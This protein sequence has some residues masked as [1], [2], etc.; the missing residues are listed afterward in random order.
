MSISVLVTYASKYG[1]TQ[2]VAESVA[3][4]LRDH[5]LT[6]DLQPMPN[7][8]AL[9][10]YDAVV[11]GAPIYNSR[12]HL[13]RFHG[14]VPPARMILSFQAIDYLSIPLVPNPTKRLHLGGHRLRG[15]RRSALPRG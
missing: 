8:T 1:S 14:I 15:Y 13:N 4:V 6:V 3:A 2:E 7:V 9:A 10:G 5:E 11:L 12:F